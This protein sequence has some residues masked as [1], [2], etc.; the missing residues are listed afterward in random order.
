M[1]TCFIVWSYLDWFL[2]QNNTGPEISKVCSMKG[3]KQKERK[4]VS[5]TNHVCTSTY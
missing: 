4:E 3:R 2:F 1:C 5:K